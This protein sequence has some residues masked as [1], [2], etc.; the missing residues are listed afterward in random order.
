MMNYQWNDLHVIMF[1]SEQ[2]WQLPG[3]ARQSYPPAVPP[4]SQLISEVCTIVKH[5]VY[6][7]KFLFDFFLNHE[8]DIAEVSSP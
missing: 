6:S 5:S 4:D 3:T 8:Q 1:L 2:I 7:N